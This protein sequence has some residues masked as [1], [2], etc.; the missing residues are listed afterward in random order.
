MRDLNTEEELY[1][2]EELYGR[3]AMEIR[4]RRVDEEIK[5]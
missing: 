5:S 4:S 3:I 1:Y 2:I